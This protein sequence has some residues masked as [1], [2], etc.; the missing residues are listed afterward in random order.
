MFDEEENNLLAEFLVVV[1]Q[2]LRLEDGLAERLEDD[3]SARS[4]RRVQ[5]KLFLC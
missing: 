1:G 2:V 4:E 3:V 5:L